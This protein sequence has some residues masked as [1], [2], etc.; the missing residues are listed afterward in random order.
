MKNNPL[1]IGN[2]IFVQEFYRIHSSLFF[3]IIAFAGG[4][5]RALEHIALGELFIS[6]PYLLLI[7]LSIW[8]AFAFFINDFNAQMIRKPENQFLSV[9]VLF[10]RTLQ[11]SIAMTVSINQLMA[12]IL[13]GLFLIGLAL[14]NNVLPP[15]LLVSVSLGVIIFANAFLLRRKLVRPPVSQSVSNSLLRPLRHFAKPYVFMIFHAVLP[16][17]VLSLTGYKLTSM[18]LL[19]STLYLYGTD[20][21]DLRLIGLASTIAFSLGVSF[22]TEWHL[23]ENYLFP[24][25]RSL[26]F[27]ITRRLAY[28]LFIILIYTL[29]EIFILIRNFPPGYDASDVALIIAFGMSIYFLWYCFLYTKDRKPENVMGIVSV[30]AI[31]FFLLILAKAPLAAIVAINFAAGI[32]FFRAYYARFEYKAWIGDRIRK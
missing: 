13:Y 31:A 15:V 19:W 32:V 28:A 29:P 23:T 14:R 5:M 12:A 16:K 7:P 3:L 17:Q 22:V 1:L 6:S 18:A 11:W 10:P 9:F 2:K 26:P 8:V 25:Y 27:S 24:L 4:F 20:V 30:G 21:Y